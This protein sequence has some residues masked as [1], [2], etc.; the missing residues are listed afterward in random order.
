[1][2]A[3]AV[4]SMFLGETMNLYLDGKK[5][6]SIYWKIGTGFTKVPKR[7]NLEY[8]DKE[9]KHFL[10]VMA[11]VV[12]KGNTVAYECSTVKPEE[13]PVDIKT[14]D[15]TRKQTRGRKRNAATK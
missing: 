8:E 9:G 7:V 13:I 11:H 4:W 10:E 12:K 6:E 3:A 5:V 15:T 14:P 1:M 2:V